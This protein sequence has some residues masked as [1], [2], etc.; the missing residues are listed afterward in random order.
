LAVPS[1]NGSTYDVVPV[2]VPKVRAPSVTVGPE[3]AP[4]RKSSVDVHV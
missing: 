1:P 2:G 4:A 3:W